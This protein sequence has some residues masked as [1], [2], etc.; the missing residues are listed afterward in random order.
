MNI[1]Q[2]LEYYHR[3]DIR[4]EMLRLAEHREVVPRYKDGGFGKRPQTLKYEREL[5]RWVREGAVSFHMSE[6]RWINPMMLTPGMRREEVDKLRVGWDL[7][8]DVDTN[9]LEFGRICAK[10]LIKALKFHEVRHYFVKFSGRTGWHIIVP[11]ETF[12]EEVNG[13]PTRKLFPEAA[14]KISQYLMDMIK[15]KLSDELLDSF[16]FEE[17]MRRSGK[18]YEEL[19]EE[20][21]FNPYSLLS[22]D[23]VAI[24]SRHLFRMP[25]SLNEKSWLVSVPVKDVMKFELE[26]AKPENVVVEEGFMEGGRPGEAR[27]LFIQA[28]E[29]EVM[30][31]KEVSLARSIP[32]E[33]IPRQ[34]FPPCIK[35][36]LKG[37]EDGRKRSVFILINF[38]R[39]LGWDFDSIEK[40]LYE[41]NKRNKEPLREN[42]IASQ[43][44]WHKKNPIYLPPNCDNRNYYLDI[45]VCQPDHLCKGIRNPVAYSF[46]SRKRYRKSR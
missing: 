13:I 5:E 11:Y 6:E 20:G 23:S 17:L 39:S 31:E 16:G 3:K 36:I 7:V 37:L 46:K 18:K 28:Y 12:P 8:L 45:G 33:A 25:Y 4:E 44:R 41:W 19:V 24:S 10:L 38:L 9:F 30:R 15:N 34:F 40:E 2:I 22:I 29:Y 27:Q 43:L 14:I 35:N 26:Q 21:E 32:K 42:Y 1:A